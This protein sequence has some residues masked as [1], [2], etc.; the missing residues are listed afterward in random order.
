MRALIVTAVTAVALA[1]AAP[2]GAQSKSVKTF[3]HSSDNTVTCGAVASPDPVWTAVTECYLRG[4]YSGQI[5]RIPGHGG[6]PGP[7]DVL[8]SASLGFPMEPMQ[9]CVSARAHFLDGVTYDT[10]LTCQTN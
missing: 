5:Y 2:A 7:V 3:S 6:A 1:A 9:I 8:T 10:P 4:L